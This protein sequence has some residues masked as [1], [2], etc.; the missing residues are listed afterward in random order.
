M[1]NKPG[2]IELLAITRQAF[3]EE[4]LSALPEERRY[5]ALMIANAMAI[6]RREIDAGDEPAKRE[7]RSLCELLGVTEPQAHAREPD[8]ALAALNRELIDNLRAGRYDR[9]HARLLKH[10]REVTEAKL[11]ISNPK[12]LGG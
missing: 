5:T 8:A 12:M 11:A 2:A 4:I 3:V 7:L 1:N 6:A 9:D 10:L